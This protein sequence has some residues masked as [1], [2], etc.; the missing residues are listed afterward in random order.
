M[1]GDCQMKNLLPSIIFGDLW[2]HRYMGRHMDTKNIFGMEGRSLWS[3]MNYPL[4]N[5]IEEPNLKTLVQLLR[6]A[7]KMN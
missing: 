2:L 5:P 1:V 7:I 4:P 3:R 6:I